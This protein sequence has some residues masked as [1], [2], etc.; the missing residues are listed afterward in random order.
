MLS[1]RFAVNFTDVDAG[2][3][4]LLNSCEGNLFLSDT[5]DEVV[6]LGDLIKKT[7]VADDVYDFVNHGGQSVRYPRP[8][9]FALRPRPEHPSAGAPGLSRV[10]CLYDNAG[11]HFQPGEDRAD[12]PVTQHMALSRVLFFVFDPTQDSR[13]MRHC[14][15]GAS[16]SRGPG[17]GRPQRQETVLNEAASRVRRIAG[18]PADAKHNR[19]LIV[20]LAK[21]DEWQHL[22]DVPA[23]GEPLLRT[24]DG[25]YALDSH[26]VAARS[27]ANKRLMKAY[28]PEIVAAA[29]D[30]CPDTTYLAVS[31]LGDEIETHAATGK[32]GIRPRKIR[33]SWVTIPMLLGLNKVDPKLVRRGRR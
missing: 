16:G 26:A 29:E 23:A 21:S 4:A 28:C 9:L 30:F 11:E 8:F 14:K 18:L 1:S 3:N 5:P 15:R 7:Q 2:S 20:I 12:A 27:E 24:R 31:S 6:P 32:L 17:G 10:L 13:L 33:P 25:V 19:P 22:I